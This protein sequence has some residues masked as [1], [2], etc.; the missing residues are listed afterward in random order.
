MNDTG[1]TG[2][3]P[4]LS[5]DDIKRYINEIIEINLRN[6]QL[7]IQ[8]VA[9][10][11][12]VNEALRSITAKTGATPDEALIMALTL[13]EVVIDAVKQGRRLVLVDGDYRFVREI[14]GLLRER[15]DPSTHEKVAG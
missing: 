8:E 9:R 15:P 3:D 2:L 10:S 1:D 12:A 4:R 5:P 11:E 6:K 13:Y 7:M 14:T